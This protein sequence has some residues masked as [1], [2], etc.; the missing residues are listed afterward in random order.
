MALGSVLRGA[1]RR[2]GKDEKSKH[3]RRP[4]LCDSAVHGVCH[5]DGDVDARPQR[6]VNGGRVVS[7]NAVDLG[8]AVAHLRLRRRRRGGG[9]LARG[10]RRGGQQVVGGR[11]GRLAQ[12][13]GCVEKKRVRVRVGRVPG[14]Q[15]PAA[16]SLFFSR[17]AFASTP[18]TLR[19]QSPR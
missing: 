3:R 4:L 13:A 6:A 19:R 1:Q 14:R 7:T 16:S 18:R 12:D 17:P 9:R 8:D 2:G 15:M 10:G 11:V 5:G